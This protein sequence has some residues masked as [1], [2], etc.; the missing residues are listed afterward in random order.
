MTTA[1]L[2]NSISETTG[3]KKVEVSATLETLTLK[4][5]ESLSKGEDK[6]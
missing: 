1:E 3:I 2:V 6:Y 5:K 4:M